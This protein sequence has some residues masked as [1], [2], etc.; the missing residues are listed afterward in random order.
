MVKIRLGLKEGVSLTAKG[1]YLTI[2]G[3]LCLLT[4]NFGLTNVSN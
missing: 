1:L 4:S 3:G 2:E